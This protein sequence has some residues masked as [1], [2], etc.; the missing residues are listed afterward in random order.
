MSIASSNST[1]SP[2]AWKN[3]IMNGDE[4]PD[5]SSASK[6]LSQKIYEALGN[7]K[8]VLVTLCI[9]LRKPDGSP[10]IDIDQTPW[11]QQLKGSVKPA[12]KDLV[13]EVQRRQK[14]FPPPSPEDKTKAKFFAIKPANKQ[15]KVL[16]EWL[17]TWPIVNDECVAFL[18]MEATR[19][20]T[21]LTTALEDSNETAL[22]MQH[23][24]WTGPI[25]YLRLLHCLTDCGATR[26]AYLTRNNVKQREE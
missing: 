15:Q 17:S 16:L 12:N 7:S 24:A 25:P 19:I 3:D 18:T 2:E 13:V 14:L 11:S 26:M 23:G 4:T 20:E 9:G 8:K 1:E 10:L 22:A 6:S 5:S 21:L